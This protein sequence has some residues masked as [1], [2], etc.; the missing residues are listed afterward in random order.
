LEIWLETCRRFGITDVLINVHSQAD[1]IEQFLAQR[2]INTPKVHVKREAELLGSAGTLDVN[3]AW[4]SSEELF[5]VFYA[6]VLNRTDL[7]AMM[8]F[9]KARNPVVTLGVYE[10][11]DPS[12]CGIVEVMEDGTVLEFVEKPTHPRSNLAFSGILIANSVMLEMIS[13]HKPLDIGFDILPK[14]AGKMLAYRIKDYLV[15]IGTMDNYQKA[16]ATWPGFE[17]ELA[18]THAARN[19]I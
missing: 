1:A 6:D 2:R 16:Q 5:W 19:R 7:R 11:A 17:G 18:Q 13:E 8:Q 14:L 4:V 10:V 15:D 12:R 9:H 3:R